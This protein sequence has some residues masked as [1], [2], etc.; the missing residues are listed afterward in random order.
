MERG[1][2]A[3]RNDF[4]VR[5]GI[6]SVNIPTTKARPIRIG[7]VVLTGVYRLAIWDVSK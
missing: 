2:L 4:W 5:V 3:T 6:G 1:A 7:R